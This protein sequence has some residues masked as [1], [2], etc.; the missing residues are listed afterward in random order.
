M[1]REKLKR[2]L[3]FKPIYKEFQ[4]KSY[5]TDET[6]H[7]LHE[8][9][10]ALYLMDIKRLYQADAA[11][12][13]GV[14]RPT[15][16][17]IIKNAREKVTMMLI[18]GANLK[19]EDNKNDCWVMI[20]SQSEDNIENSIPTASYLHLYEIEHKRVISKKII[21]NPVDIQKLKP[22]QVIPIIC[23]KY[24]INFF[25]SNGIGEGLK[26]ALLSKGVYS[27][28]IKEKITLEKICSLISN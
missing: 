20:P 11:K 3:Q 21:Y 23:N 5:F 9:M 28:I 26:N 10:E 13:M 7:L 8:E 25:I 12:S 22:G 6:I 27:V 17:R 2:N 15:F 24:N 19:I 18:T 16:A 14:S 4:S 1:G